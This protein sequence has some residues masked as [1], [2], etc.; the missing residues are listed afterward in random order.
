MNEACGV[1]S[2]EINVADYVV[3]CAGICKGKYHIKC[4]K[5]S[6]KDSQIISGNDN[7]KWYCNRCIGY[8]DI[9]LQLLDQF[10]NFQNS[11]N[12]QLKGFKRTLENRM[13]IDSHTPL[14][15]IN[16]SK[17]KSYSEA[18][19][20][21]VIIKP[22]IDQDCKMTKEEIQK[23]INPQTLEVGI[24]EVKNI[25]DGGLLIKCQNKNDSEKVKDAVENKL[26]QKYDIKV[27]ELI[28]PCVKIVGL[29]ESYSDKELEACLVKQ[30]SFIQH[31]KLLLK[32]KVVKK[33]K[34]RF[35]AI[36]ETDPITHNRILDKGKLSVG[37]SMC[38]VF[39]YVAVLKCYNCWGYNH[40]ASECKNGK[41]CLKC[42]S[43]AHSVD[44]CVDEE[45]KC[46]NCVDANA[47]LELKLDT[48]HSPL[49]MECPCLQRK[50][51]LQKRRVNSNTGT[52]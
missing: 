31:D 29:E 42:A 26:R 39:D 9:A 30:N 4:A 24:V 17:T 10:K 43:S 14:E 36:V 46:A 38:R 45:W 34:S 5:I 27:P 13:P 37:W 28:N 20:N 18:A 52:E 25:K 41:K 21:V 12:D 40:K 2:T 44:Q 49:S 1:C 51:E 16:K 7:I 35:M 15:V 33:M 47:S 11:I 8:H 22:K 48:R 6:N 32:I 23:S 3:S 50:V 19:K